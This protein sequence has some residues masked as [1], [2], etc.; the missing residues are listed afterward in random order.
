MT[1]HDELVFEVKEESV[2]KYEEIIK[3]TMTDIEGF[4]EIL[5]VKSKTGRI[6]SE[7]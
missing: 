4:K 2:E 5:K 3:E 1:I 7:L 6:W